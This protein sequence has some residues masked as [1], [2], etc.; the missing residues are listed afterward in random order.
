MRKA[1]YNYGKSQFNLQLKSFKS[2]LEKQGYANDTIRP[3]SNYA[4]CFLE[5][6]EGEQIE[7]TKASYPDLMKFIKHYQN[8][9]VQ[10][11]STGN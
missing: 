5:W 1:T 9:T 6:L 2:W 11:Y 4:G 10:G 7:A 3:Y 8:K